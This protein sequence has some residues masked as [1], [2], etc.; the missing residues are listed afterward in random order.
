MLIMIMAMV[1][2]MEISI[3]VISLRV[4]KINYRL[5]AILGRNYRRRGI[6]SLIINSRIMDKGILKLFLD[7]FMIIILITKIKIKIT[8]IT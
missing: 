6:N 5:I 4:I 1:M 7:I 3:I 2:V 8:Q